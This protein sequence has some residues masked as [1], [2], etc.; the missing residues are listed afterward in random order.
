MHLRFFMKTVMYSQQGSHAVSENKEVRICQAK[1]VN[2]NC[3]KAAF[4]VKINK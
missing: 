3:T 2:K 1:V 4:Y